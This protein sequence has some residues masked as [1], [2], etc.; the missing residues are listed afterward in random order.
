MIEGSSLAGA[1][2]ESSIFTS[3]CRVQVKAFKGE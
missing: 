2:T 3:G 1:A